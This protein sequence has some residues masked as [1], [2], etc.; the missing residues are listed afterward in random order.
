VVGI[1]GGMASGKSSL[2][3][4]LRRRGASIY[5]VDQAAHALYLPG[6][7]AWRKIIA[8]FGRRVV[9]PDGSIDRRALG[10]AVYGNAAMMRRLE[11]ILHRPLAVL[12][13]AAIR[14]MSLRHRL[15]VVEAG[16]ILFKLK[17]DRLANLVVVT[18]CGIKERIR[19]LS[20]SSGLPRPAA[21]RRIGSFTRV[22]R[23]L[24]RQAAATGRGMTV[25]T[26]WPPARLDAAADAVLGRIGWV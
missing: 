14:R 11:R 7:P 4:V 13:A 18:E 10:K 26:D 12:A 17:L 2:A 9:A 25:R 19:R 1:T 20:R 15:V 5:S 8:G 23:S 22:D 24:P 21:K 6:K 3:A 16:P